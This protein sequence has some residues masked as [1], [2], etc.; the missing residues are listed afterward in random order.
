M[1]ATSAAAF[2]YGAVGE[3]LGAPAHD[4]IQ[5]NPVVADVDSAAVP[6]IISPLALIRIR[7]TRAVD[8]DGVVAKAI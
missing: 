2:V 7:S 8:P 6:T 4:G 3:P 1:S 5:M